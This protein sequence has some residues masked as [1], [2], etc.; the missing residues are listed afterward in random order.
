MAE[1]RD[2]YLDRELGAISAVGVALEPLSDKECRRVVAWAKERFVDGEKIGDNIN[3]DK[4]TEWMN[5]VTQAAQAMQVPPLKVMEAMIASAN[6]A[7]TKHPE[8]GK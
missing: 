4:I 3:I 8:G 1:K 2:D 5:E 6:E 7:A